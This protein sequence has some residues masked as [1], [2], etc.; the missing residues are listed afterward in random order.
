MYPETIHPKCTPEFE[1]RN[2]KVG[3]DDALSRRIDID[4]IPSGFASVPVAVN[5]NGASY[6]TMM[7]A[8]LIRTQATPSGPR[9]DG[10]KYPNESH[11]CPPTVEAENDSIQPLSGW[12]IYEK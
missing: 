10:S 1:T 12:W 7:V 6:S 8:G 9:S 4:D 11:L 5:E 2:T 3:L